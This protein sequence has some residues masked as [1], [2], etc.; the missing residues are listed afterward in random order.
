MSEATRERRALETDLD[1]AL[2]NDALELHYQPIFC[3]KTKA[4]VGYEALARW[5]HPTRGFVSPATFIQIAE[6]TGM[7]ERLGTFVLD[8]A[9]RD[10]A[11]W[12]DGLKVAVNCSPLQFKSGQLVDVVIAT[13]Q[14]YG[15]VAERLEIEITESAL[16]HRDKVTQ[17]QL[18]RLR[19]M[20]VRI[21]MDD[22][23]TGYSS[24]SYL[25]TYPISCIKIDRAFVSTLG[26][27]QSA[28]AIIRAIV[29]LSEALNMMTIAEGVETQAQLDE[30]IAL[31]CTEAQG[32]LLGRPMTVSKLPNVVRA[33]GFEAKRLSEAA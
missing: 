31:G 10:A 17:D 27:Q 15:I 22:F 7:I 32:Y 33:P 18:H 13:L 5:I 9:C 23:G 21:S 1:A 2:K 19:A 14:R 20:G 24:L 12:P 29:M 25:Q 8:R 26:T 6:D 16:M 4:I 11:T 28:A 3:L 30:L